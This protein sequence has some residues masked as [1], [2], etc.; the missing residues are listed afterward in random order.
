MAGVKNRQ[1]ISLKP[2]GR[3][4]IGTDNKVKRVKLIDKKKRFVW[5]DENGNFHPTNNT[6]LR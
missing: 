2:R 4:V 5:M 1:G 3:Y 6:E